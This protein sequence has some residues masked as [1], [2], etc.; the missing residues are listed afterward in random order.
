MT[1]QQ[2]TSATFMSS[3]RW[4]CNRRF[5]STRYCNCRGTQMWA[6]YHQKQAHTAPAGPARQ[7]HTYH[8]KQAHTAPPGP[9]RQVR[10]YHQ[11]QAHA[12]AVRK[13]MHRHR[14]NSSAPE[15]QTMRARTVS[16]PAHCSRQAM[17]VRALEDQVLRALWSLLADRT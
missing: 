5:A 8:Q 13:G 16:V 1:N 11:R 7:V 9:A 15:V 10:A 6:D 4:A 17:R 3:P 2:R 14:R 12:V